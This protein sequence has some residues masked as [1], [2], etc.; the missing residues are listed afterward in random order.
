V[1]VGSLGLRAPKLLELGVAAHKTRE[2]APGGG[3]L[4]TRATGFWTSQFVYV[5]GF[6]EREPATA[7]ETVPQE[8]VAK[9]ERRARQI[10]AEAPE[11]DVLLHP[12]IGYYAGHSE[13]Y[14][15]NVIAIA[16]KAARDKMPAIRSALARA[17][18]PLAQAASTARMPAGD[19]SR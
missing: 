5:H 8:W 6:G 12:N 17:G 2:P 7:I 15:R 9:D 4:Q 13:T 18:V 16:E 10:A 1:T 3:G 14:R 19:A 11:A